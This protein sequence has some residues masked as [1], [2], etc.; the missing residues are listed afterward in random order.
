MGRR[1]ATIRTVHAIPREPGPLAREPRHAA[2]GCVK[3]AVR[4]RK[5][6]WKLAG[7]TLCGAIILGEFVAVDQWS[8]ATRF[9]SANRPADISASNAQAVHR[10]VPSGSR[11]GVIAHSNTPSPP[12]KP[13]PTDDRARNG[14]P[15]AASRAAR[16][17]ALQTY[18]ALPMS[19][20][21]NAGQSDPRVKF[22]AHTTGYSLFLADQEAVLSLLEPSP[23]Q[24][25]LRANDPIHHGK[26]PPPQR[27]AHAVRIKFA[28]GSPAAVVAGS[29][30]LA[31][32]SNY[33]I[34]N[35]PKLWRTNVPN[36][37]AVKYS[38]IYPGVDAVFHGNN[39]RLEFDFD[40]AAGANPR[41][42]AL[43]VDGARR[44]RLNRAGD[45][46]LGMDAAHQLVMNK[47]H[48]Y[49][50]ILGGRR[51]IAG[52]YV[53]GAG[54]RIAFAISRY[55]HT[56]P[57]VIDPTLVYSTYLD[58]GGT[59]VGGGTIA[60]AI[61][62]D[63]ASLSD[64]SPG[65]PTDCSAGC[66]VVTGQVGLSTL[67][68]PATSGSY[69]TG[70]A[71]NWCGFISKLNPDG[72]ALVYSTYFCGKNQYGDGSDEI[73]AIAVDSTGAAYFG[74]LSAYPD[75][76]P[77]TPG[78]YEPNRPSN[79]DA[80]F[81]AK[82]SPDG[83]TL[84]YSTFL[85][86]A[87]T[88]ADDSVGGI[89]VDS[90]F[91]AYVTGFTT[92]TAFPTTTGAFQTAF[93]GG[94]EGGSAFVT[95][96]SADGSSLVYSTYLGGSGLEDISGTRA[97]GAI[98]AIALDSSDDAYV[99]GNTT[100]SNFPTMNPYIATC[101]S[102]CSEAFVSELNPTGTGLV[103][104]TF[105]GGSTANQY[106]VGLGI[107]VDS[108]NCA[109]LSAGE[110]CS[111]FV[112]GDTTFTNFPVTSPVVQSSPGVGF[113]TKLAPGGTGLVYSSY[114][115]GDV[116]SV[117]VGPDD[118]AVIFGLTSTAYGFESTAGA[119]TLPA[120]TANGGC[121]FDFIAKLATDGSGLLFSTPIGA[122]QE[123]CG[124]FG[125][126][127]STGNAYIVGS[128][129]STQLPTTAGSFE[130]TLPSNSSAADYFY[131]AKVA[132]SSS[133]TSI[134]ISP[135]A[136]SYGFEEESYSETFTATGGSGTG[137]SWS[138]ISGGTALTN[139]GL[140]LT[141]GGVIS[142]TPNATETAAAFTVKV[143]DSQ[144]NS[145]TQ[146][147]TLTIYPDIVATPTTLPAGTVG[148]PYSQPLTASGGSGGPFTFAVVA[149]TGLSAVGLT[150]SSGGLISGTPTGTE[151]AAAFTV[152]IA[153]SLGDF[154]QQPYTLTVNAAT[155]SSPPV[156]DQ[157]TV[158]VSETDAVNAFTLPAAINL[159]EPVAYFTTGSPLAF[160]GETGAQQTIAIADIG[161]S[162]LT[163]DSLAISSGAPFTLSAITC[164]NGATVSGA[165]ATIPASGFCT[166]TIT[167]TGSSPSTDTGTLTFTDNASASNLPTAR[168][169]P[170]YTQSIAL[171][172]ECPTGLTCPVAPPPASVSVPDQETV[173]VSETDAVNAFTLAAPIAV[174]APVADFSSGSPLGF[175]GQ[176]GAQQTIA[177]ADAGQAALALD[178]IAFS[179][180]APFT[181][182]AITCFNGATVSG[183]G[184]TIPAS[185]FC[186]LTI[187]YTGSSPS[188]DT[189]TLTFTDNAS[190]SNLPTAASGS[191][192]TQSITL[193]GSGTS[194]APP[195]A[196]VSVPDQETVTVT[197]SV[198]LSV[199]NPVP[200]ISSTS[201]VYAAGGGSAFTLTVNGS[202]FVPAT[203]VLWGGTALTTTYV[204]TTELT[205]A[206]PASEITTTG[207]VA[208]SV[209]TPPPGGG[210]ST[211]WQ[212]EVS[213]SGN[214]T[215]NP[216]TTTGNGS[217]TPGSSATFTVT[218]PTGATN[219]TVQCL[220]LPAGLNWS[221][222][223]TNPDT[224]TISTSTNTPA[225]TYTVV[226]VFTYTVPGAAS[227]SLIV[228]PILLLPLVFARRRWAKGR[229]MPLACLGLV[230][231]ITLL[232][233]GCGGGSTHQAT[234]TGTVT[235]IVQ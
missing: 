18:A 60:N 193:T 204:S 41:S 47:P 170:N 231:M 67:P 111:V 54:N 142:G 214:G 223:F 228:F 126:L 122:N 182:S 213:P 222:S 119:L 77:T 117:A 144:G 226:V 127:D 64:A 57:L 78:S 220:D 98:G 28:G 109:S 150:L 157:E 137:Y 61:A 29:D 106:S 53:L 13:S 235:L 189:G 201:P 74:G 232:N 69:D 177:I 190:A 199:S 115:N 99:T 76:T 195:P 217:V 168:S 51:E 187:T 87:T 200:V 40:I 131:A 105:L 194:A 230:L 75:D 63:N 175:G 82:L 94:F 165:G 121:F 31:A 26:A 116:E 206:V 138:V 37:S 196:S 129:S 152:Q 219:I 163:L 207:T 154:T 70:P 110:S 9:S 44:M 191:N 186:T 224:L 103:Y 45:V 3:A 33:F 113:I 159:N 158:A 92:S 125:A 233:L 147:Y 181:L 79:S 108:S 221:C 95:K 120:C 140:S 173:T 188:T 151:T 91:N 23:T 32:K 174:S 80:P 169:S 55:D 197:D 89:A 24:R 124:A 155:S 149:G 141:T 130:P 72:S 20:E 56:R 216:P 43:E 48:V 19:F 123:C 15:L 203:T 166:L 180:S 171:D 14:E 34:G 192:Y 234:S 209:Q 227:S 102:P 135:S 6:R 27:A 68:F 21:A 17:R 50:E 145:A 10:S 1:L 164:F 39:R 58:A 225:G 202:G 4:R 101:S 146:P 104:S 46:V 153:D 212:F 112:G 62:V 11:P 161:Q 88:D 16:S 93:P 183:A 49:Q 36:Y 178:S 176:T 90:S 73:L 229:I 66:A 96:L 210:T 42:I 25:P 12:S 35:D 22:L 136:L 30:E 85:D 65:E 132:F 84:V 218:L 167:Y 172:G 205:A 208:I 83:S 133:S 134:T 184:A 162:A 5:T 114:F 59:T 7:A 118:S 139:V 38:G 160:G 156:T 97:L 86:G 71:P 128:T 8:R 215:G 81:V 107:A 211:T 148:V 52:R 143:T 2:K 100:S 179:S 198:Q 185:G